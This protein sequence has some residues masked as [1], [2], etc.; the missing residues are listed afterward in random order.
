MAEKA[1][2]S[3]FRFLKLNDINLGSGKRSI[4]PAGVYLQKY[5]ITV[6]Q[7]LEEYGRI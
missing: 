6:P 2:H 3:W 5:Q 7:K 4:V 1:G